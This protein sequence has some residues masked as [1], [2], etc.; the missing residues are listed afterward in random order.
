VQWIPCANLAHLVC[1]DFDV[2]DNY[3][4]KN[5]KNLCGSNIRNARERHVPAITQD[6]LAG[7]LATLGLVLDRTAIAKIELGQRCVYDYE[8]GAFACALD[9]EISSLIQPSRIRR[10]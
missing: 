7:K 8:L 1:Y 5:S 2:P 9:I 4:P 6:Q 10:K 3:T